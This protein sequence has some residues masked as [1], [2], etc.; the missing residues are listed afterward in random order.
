MK[1]IRTA[2]MLGL[3]LVALPPL[4][5]AQ[6]V[7]KS[8][9]ELRLLVRAG[10]TITITD[11]TG[12]EVSGK[13]SDLS[14]SSLTLLADSRPQEWRESDVAT[15]SQRRGDSLANGALTGLV[16]GA[17]LAAVAIA[18]EVNRTEVGVS[19]G[20]GALVVGIYGGLGAA[21]GTG[22][23]A[24]ITTDQVI[25]EKQSASGAWLRVAPFLTPTRAGARVSIGF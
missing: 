8:F 3:C 13:I 9:D 12:R 7:A 16:V 1:T 15:I 2:T 25:F 4:V 6:G 21:I 19:A 11:L 17:G 20:E 14:A 23:D 10:D 5:V 22:V 24:L 18:I